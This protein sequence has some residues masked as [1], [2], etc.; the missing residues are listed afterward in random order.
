MFHL[1][2]QWLTKD[3]NTFINKNLTLVKDQNKELES[4][5]QP[6]KFLREYEKTPGYRPEFEFKATLQ[7]S[8]GTKLAL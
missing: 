7:A 2:D 6:D 3:A 5:L 1:P 8:I 4:D